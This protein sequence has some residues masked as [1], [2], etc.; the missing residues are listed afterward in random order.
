MAQNP[1]DGPRVIISDAITE[2]DT[3]TTVSAI[4]IPAGTYIPPYG[5]S[6]EVAEDFAGGTPLLDVGDSGDPDGWIDQTEITAT[7]AAH[8]AGV[9]AGLAVAGKYYATADQIEVVVS[10]SLTDGT[11]YV[12]AQMFNFS[13]RSLA[14]A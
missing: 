6:I 7:T 12:V 8:Y 14:A 5:V 13:N 2:A 4:E 3:G 9:A 1:L 10:A 11:A